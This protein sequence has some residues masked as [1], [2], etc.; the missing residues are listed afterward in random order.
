MK[1]EMWKRHK[2]SLL[3][4]YDPIIFDRSLT[5][6][7]KEYKRLRKVDNLAYADIFGVLYK[8]DRESYNGGYELINPIEISLSR[9]PFIMI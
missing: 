1:M 7:I 5:F 4:R 8:G 3:E 2:T 9:D 6:S